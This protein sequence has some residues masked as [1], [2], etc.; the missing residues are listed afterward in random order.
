MSATAFSVESQTA[1]SSDLKDVSAD[2]CI[3]TSLPGT[4][5]TIA[6]RQHSHVQHDNV[7]QLQRHICT[8][9]TMCKAFQAEAKTDALTNETEALG[10]GT[11]QGSSKT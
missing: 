8:P 1:L 6:H 11:L 4:A 9:V 10:I 7:R 3:A 2:T 5:R